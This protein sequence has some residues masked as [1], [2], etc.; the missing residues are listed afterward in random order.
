[1]SAFAEAITSHEP[2]R[3]AATSPAPSVCPQPPNA[4]PATVVSQTRIVT[5][6]LLRSQYARS[7]GIADSDTG[8]LAERRA[9]FIHAYCTQLGQSHARVWAFFHNLKMGYTLSRRLT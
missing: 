1:L 7:F 8:A 5:R 9:V 6:G 3:V 2:M 4:N